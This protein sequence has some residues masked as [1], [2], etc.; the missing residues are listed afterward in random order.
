VC[1]KKK[2]HFF[3]FGTANAFVSSDLK[4]DC[5]IRFVVYVST[6]AMY[7]CSV[8]ELKPETSEPV[9]PGP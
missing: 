6:T 4:F 9:P 1:D 8:A 3:G 2:T 7:Q 5:Q